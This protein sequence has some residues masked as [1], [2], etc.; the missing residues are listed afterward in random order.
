[1]NQIIKFTIL[2]QFCFFCFS[3]TSYSTTYYVSSKGNDENSGTSASMPWRSLEKVNSFTPNSGDSIL[4]RRGDEWIG[5]VTI[6][7][8]GLFGQPVVY[9]AYGN[10]PKPKFYGSE[11]IKGWSLH[12]GNIYKAVFEKPI[13][14]LFI[15]DKRMRAARYPD[16]GYFFL[17]SVQSST[18]FTATDLNSEIDYNGAKCFMRTHYWTT[19]LF[20]I[21]SAEANELTIDKAPRFDLNKDEG[22][23][24]MD[25]LEFLNQPGE[26]FYDKGTQ[27]V[28]F[29]T[30]DGDTPDNYTIRGSVIA[31]GFL[32]DKKNF[33]T[34]Q[35]M[36]ILHHSG[37]G[38]F[39]N[40]SKY[41]SIL[42]NDLDNL[43]AF[44]IYVDGLSERVLIQNN[45]VTGANHLGIWGQLSNSTISDNVVKDIALFDNIGLTGNGPD[46]YGSGIQTSGGSE[47]NFIRYNTI[48]NIGYNGISFGR[49]H[50]IEYNYIDSVCLLKT[51]GGGIYTS[52][53]NRVTPTG[54][55]G[56]VIKYNIVLNAVGETY[57]FTSSRAM[58]EGIYVDESSLG[59]TVEYNTIAH[60][61]NSGIK[62]HKTE[63][64]TVSHN[65]IMDARS[66]IYNLKSSGTVKSRITNNKITALNIKY[67]KVDPTHQVLVYHTSDGNAEYDY[68]TYYNPFRSDKFFTSRWD[69]YYSFPQ[70]KNY[71]KGDNNSSLV[72]NPLTAGEEIKLFYNASK[73]SK[74]FNLN[75]AQ[76]R[77]MEGKSY[78]SSF[79]LEP[80]TSVILIGKNMEYIKE[81]ITGNDKV[82]HEESLRCSP[83]PFHNYLTIE[84]GNTSEKARVEIYDSTGTL[85]LKIPDIYFNQ[86]KTSFTWD[87]RDKNGNIVLP[88]LYFI[89]LVSINRIETCKVLRSL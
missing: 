18:R 6:N 51:D 28:Y 31:N 76:V 17:S 45:S 34:I 78:T 66:C 79:S 58:G 26:W 49:P 71:I 30:P 36:N 46:N 8:S 41:I 4:F 57:G 50:V 40:Q 86:G 55:V 2:I 75:D 37:K 5:T 81:T 63:G 15:D 38:I 9:G 42:N 47:P 74:T 67:A 22:F 68:N 60:C 72:N 54:N 3:L 84:V 24:L 10:G 29:W 65:T 80:F 12:E 16:E 44:G 43:D 32:A 21:T 33:V 35:D 39:V 53:Y 64:T 73:S 23:F 14:Q 88:G 1:M 52:W 13:N 87:G 20:N 77:D 62:L 27:T 7:G 59:V 69:A 19:D 82:K 11:E 89:Q 70:W 83:N 61:G 56:S 85:I 48:K 25:K